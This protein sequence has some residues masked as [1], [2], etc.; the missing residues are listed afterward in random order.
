[1]TVLLIIARSAAGTLATIQF[2]SGF[3]ASTAIR[4]RLSMTWYL[5]GTRHEAHQGT[6]AALARGLP[7]DALRARWLL[8]VGGMM[9][10]ADLS[11]LD[12]LKLIAEN[13]PGPGTKS[14]PEAMP[15]VPRKLVT[16]KLEILA[17]QG[18]IEY[19]VILTRPWLT[20][21]GREAIR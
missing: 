2:L 21:K 10:L 16:K 6:T 4:L 13:P 9:K 17:R 19:G 15:A 5:A 7:P 1:M 14:I 20:A 12:M 18:L 8:A 11:S 3:S